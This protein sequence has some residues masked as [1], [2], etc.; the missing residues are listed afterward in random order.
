MGRLASRLSYRIALTFPCGRL[1]NPFPRRSLPVVNALPLDLRRLA[2]PALAAILATWAA[3]GCSVHYRQ[4]PDYQQLDV[5]LLRPLQP[6]AE[7]G[8]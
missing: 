5:E 8:R 3:F 4:R 7:S 2:R 6:P 1:D